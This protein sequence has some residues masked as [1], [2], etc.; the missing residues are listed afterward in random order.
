MKLLIRITTLSVFFVFLIGCNPANRNSARIIFTAYED[1][2]VN[3]QKRSPCND[4]MNYQ[5]G[6]KFPE[7]FPERVVE[8]N[9][10][11]M[12]EDDGSG[13]FPKGM[14]AYNYL[15]GILASANDRFRK[16][17]KM[18][19]P[20]GNNT[21]VHPPRIKLALHGVPGSINDNGVYY[22]DNSELCYINTAKRGK[23]IFSTKQ[24]ENYGVQKGKVINVF[25]MEHHPDSL[26]SETYNSGADGVGPGNW[27][28]MLG[29]YKTSK[30]SVVLDGKKVTKPAWW[31]AGTFAHEIGH[32][33]GLSHTWNQNDGCEDTPRHKN[34]WDKEPNGYCATMWSYNM[35]DYNCVQSS[36]SPCQIAKMHYNMSRPGSKQRSYLRKTWC[37]YKP[38]KQITIPADTSFVWAC[39]KDI[40][41]DIILEKG[42]SL[43]MHCRV[44]MPQSSKIVV[45]PGATLVLDGA[46]LYN[47]CD[48]QWKGI[49]VL[50]EGKAEGAVVMKNNAKL[51]DIR[52]PET[53]AKETGS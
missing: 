39:H 30:D 29:Y 20:L 40:E 10:H 19:L 24:Y 44:S 13:N 22:H 8:L 41:S 23:N 37:N 33:L 51:E 38:D 3:D 28:K 46:T 17:K 7:M 27:V 6:T 34:C 53:E 15:W 36:L 31:R 43:T 35:M 11:I 32:C 4:I 16:N 25:F 42:S 14:E 49:V 48:Q 5:T 21:P 12:R 9:F 50:K 2:E 52:L 47:D 26:T 18:N 45:Q 1:Q